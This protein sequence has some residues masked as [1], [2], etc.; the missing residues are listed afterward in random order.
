M[1]GNVDGAHL[2]KGRDFSAGKVSF[3][4]LPMGSLDCRAEGHVF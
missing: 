4:H 1:G 3:R 2:T